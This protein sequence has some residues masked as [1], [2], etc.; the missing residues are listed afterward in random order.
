MKEKAVAI[1]DAFFLTRPILLIPVISFCAL[2]YMENNTE[3]FFTFSISTPFVFNTI[4]VSLML[5]AV[6]IINRLTDKDAD[7]INS[8]PSVIPLKPSTIIYSKFIVVLLIAIS[9][10]FSVSVSGSVNTIFVVAALVIGLFYS[11]KPFY[12]TG[13][14]FADFFCNALG[15][16]VVCVLIGITSA[17]NYSVNLNNI[18]SYFLLMSA[19]SIA[20]TTPDALGDAKSGKITTAVFLG[21]G[22]ALIL[23][24]SFLIVA[25]ASGIYEG[26]LVVIVTS[27]CS[28]AAFL[29][30]IIKPSKAAYSLSYQIGGGVLIAMIHIKMPTLF[31]ASGVLFLATFLYYR[32]RFSKTY[33]AV[34]K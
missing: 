33:P 27:V 10:G 34:G 29:Y 19:G 18:A 31:V 17:E 30:A 26:N 6:H 25:L 5:M 9:L 15:Y 13:K 7:E 2:G 14:P 28:I 8:G 20:S 3:Q 11:L 12:L 23:G 4:F 22:R 1:F 16:G 21:E 32:I 24:I